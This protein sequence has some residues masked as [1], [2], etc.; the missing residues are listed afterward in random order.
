MFLS[1]CLLM[2]EFGCK[3]TLIFLDTYVIFRQSFVFF[4]QIPNILQK[5]SKNAHFIEEWR[6]SQKRKSTLRWGIFLE[7]KLPRKQQ[8]TERHSSRGNFKVIIYWINFFLIY[9]PKENVWSFAPW[10]FQENQR[11]W[12]ENLTQKIYI[13]NTQRHR[14]YFEHGK[15][16]KNGNFRLLLPCGQWVFDK[17][18]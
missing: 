14:D 5:K 12:P 8:I 1:V 6:F 2:Y 9:F 16:G 15:L 3:I 18:L 17:S 4:R 7:S 11:R 10:G 13:L